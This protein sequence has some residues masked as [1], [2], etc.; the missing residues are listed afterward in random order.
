MQE[1]VRNASYV[2]RLSIFHLHYHRHCR[3]FQ[4]IVCCCPGIKHF[5]NSLYFCL[6]RV[7]VLASTILYVYLCVGFWQSSIRLSSTKRR[8]N[9]CCCFPFCTYCLASMPPLPPLVAHPHSLARLGHVCCPLHWEFWMHFIIGRSCCIP[10]TLLLLHTDVRGD[11]TK[12][13]L[14]RLG[15]R[16]S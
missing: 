12:N 8:Q 4:S 10:T 11:R 3:S 1:G 5:P 9:L 6:H 13:V 16:S 14:Q 7:F 2:N 15:S